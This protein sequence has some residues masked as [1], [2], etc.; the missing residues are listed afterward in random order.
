MTISKSLEILYQDPY[1][2]AVNK[3]AG[4]LV[5]RSS[6][7]AQEKQF[8]LQI[9]RNQIDQ[10]V[11]PVHRLDRPTAGVLLFA[12]NSE[13]AK[14][15][16]ELF[17]KGNIIKKY[18]AIVRGYTAEWGTIQYNMKK[19]KNGGISC[20]NFMISNECYTESNYKRLATIEIDR[21]VDKYPTSRYSLISLFPKTGRRHQ[22]RRHMKHIRHPIIG[23]IKYGNSTHNHF[24]RDHLN[25][26]CL[27]LNAVALKFQHPITGSQIEISARLSMQ[28]KSVLTEFN[29][30]SAVESAYI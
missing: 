29:W 13:L 3:P 4:L 12:L 8:A 23:D 10:H 15:I 5:H 26:S 17:Q 16:A 9:V 6:I 7:A 25:C 1:L 11:F 30:H 22:L 28:F 14:K 19:I 2:I 27:L 21:K 18:V 20:Q 24:F